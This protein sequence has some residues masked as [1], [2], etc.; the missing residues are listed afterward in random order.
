MVN[1]QINKQLI[2]EEDSNIEKNDY[3][4]A[5]LKYP[6]E[7]VFDEDQDDVKFYITFGRK[8]EKFLKGYNIIYYPIYLIVG[9]EVVS[10]IGILEIESE[11]Y[12]KVVDEDGNIDPEKTNG[13]P[14]FFSFLTEAY[15]SNKNAIVVSDNSDTESEKKD[16]D[17]ESISS[18]DS[19]DVSKKEKELEENI[20]NIPENKLNKRTDTPKNDEKILFKIDTSIK[21]PNSLI[22]ETKSMAEKLKSEFTESTRNEWIEIFMKNNK[23]GIQDNEGGGD[24]FF[25]VIRDSFQ[26]IGKMTTIEKLREILSEEANDEIFQQYRS[27]YLAMED[28]IVENEKEITNIQNMIK[29]Y[30]RRIRSTVQGLTKVEHQDIL[31]QAKNATKRLE[32][33]KK[34]NHENAEFL[35]YNFGFMKN[36]DSL[37]AFQEYIKTSKYWADTWAISTLEYKLNIKLI[38][39][40]EE[41]FRD[42]SLDSVLNCGEMSVVLQKQ[43]KFIPDYYIMTAY[44]GVHY[45]LVTYKDKKIFD[46]SEIPYDVKVLVLNKCMERNSGIFYLIQDFRNL[47]SKIG[48]SPDEGKPVD[49]KEDENDDVYLASLYD[50]NIVFVLDS[51]AP[52]MKEPGTTAQGEKIPGDKKRDFMKLSKIKAWRRKLHDSWT[53]SP[54]TLDGKTWASVEH[55]YQGSKFRKQHPDFYVKFSL[56]SKDSEFNKDVAEAKIAGRKSKNKYRPPNISIDPDFYDGER[57][58]QERQIALKSKFEQNLDLKELLLLTQSAKLVIFVRQSPA[59]LDADLMNLRRTFQE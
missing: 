42:G 57:S 48:L 26:E 6:I 20:F 2:Y 52:I 37:E 16:S 55:Y 43:G 41:S 23:Y 29:E 17:V 45:K 56:D 12:D 18:E 32:N 13:E 24:C 30:K 9:S 39:F 47:K 14:L 50:P 31:Q 46:F 8:N 54:F 1:S 35:R 27:V 59:E 25:A 40:S 10:K 28:G 44:S 4:F 22:E 19:T 5:S 11:Q 51:N 36:I 49:D 7:I 34:E 33:L 3:D 58:H 53:E 21:M 38:I 15:L